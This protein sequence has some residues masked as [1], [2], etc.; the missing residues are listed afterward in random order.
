MVMFCRIYNG[1]HS[2]A[3]VVTGSLLGVIIVLFMN[4]FDNAIDMS[5]ITNGS[6][7]WFVIV[8]LLSMIY[9]FASLQHSEIFWLAFPISSF[10]CV[11]QAK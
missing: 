11:Y 7:K 3:D 9:L 2:P 10:S 6:G 5:S 4:R 1:V 8:S